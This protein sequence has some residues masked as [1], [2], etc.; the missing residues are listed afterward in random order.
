M[1]TRILSNSLGVEIWGLEADQPLSPEAIAEIFDL[2]L[3]H[4]LVVLRGQSI[5]MDQLGAFA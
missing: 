5:D 2:F 4:H 3:K 1:D